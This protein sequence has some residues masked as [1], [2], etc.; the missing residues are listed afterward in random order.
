M[1]NNKS[2]L[3]KRIIGEIRR[4]NTALGKPPG[5][6]VF[7][8]E[9]GIAQH[10]WDGKLWARWSDALAEAGCAANLMNR[11]LDSQLILTKYVE[12]CRYY[13]RVPSRSELNLYKN[14]SA[15]F[16]GPKTIARHFGSRAEIIAALTKLAFENDEF[17][18]M[19]KMLPVDTDVPNEL[20]VG[21]KKLPLGYVYLIKSGAH[22]KVGRSDEIERRIKEIRTALPEKASLIHTITTDDP[23]GIEAYWH[24]RFKD[25]RANGEWFKLTTAE[26]AAFKKRKFQ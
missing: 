6:R 8:Q 1:E 20:S 18:D 19:A 17:I 5:V 7:Y 13:G 14:V 16:P 25:S 4:L 23:P 9:T 22:Y 12:A 21:T 3:R 2:E 15:G 10:E 24:N 26:I 11:R